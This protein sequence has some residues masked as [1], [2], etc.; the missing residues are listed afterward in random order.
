[1]STDEYKLR[2]TYHTDLHLSQRWLPRYFR[3]FHIV[4]E[5]LCTHIP[6]NA[7]IIDVGSGEG[8]LIEVL[9][10]AG[11]VNAFG[12][13]AFAPFKLNNMIRGMIQNNPVKW[14]EDEEYIIL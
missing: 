4:K 10:A 1:M 2:G 7:L 5:I 14:K 11:F 13:D 12:I 6:H 8:E 9:R 3:R